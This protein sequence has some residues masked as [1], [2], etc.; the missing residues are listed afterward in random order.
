MTQ[1]P[2]S[3][4]RPYRKEVLVRFSHC[5]MAGIV[6][7]PRYLEMFNDLVED[8]FREELEFGFPEMHRVHRRGLPTVR[9]EVDFT[10]PSRIG[11]VLRAELAVLELGRSSLTI[12]IELRGPDASPRVAGKVV[13]VFLDLESGRAIPIPQEL[14]A[15]ME[16]FRMSDATRSGLVPAGET[17]GS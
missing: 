4:P 13:L 2:T 7:Y 6:F 14:R 11:E 8:W 1:L 10:A 17:Q 9:L 15:R 16:R 5:D 3:D 12:R